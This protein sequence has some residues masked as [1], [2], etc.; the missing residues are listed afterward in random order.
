MATVTNRGV[1]RAVGSLHQAL[2]SG[3]LIQWLID[4][5]RAPSA[6]DLATAL[7]AIAGQL[8]VEPRTD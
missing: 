3:V 1:A 2:L 7:Q 4:P 8:L 5:R 6:T